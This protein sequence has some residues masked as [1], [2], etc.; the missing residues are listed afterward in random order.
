[1]NL[2][3]FALL[4]GVILLIGFS[5]NKSKLLGTPGGNMNGL[6]TAV[7]AGGCYWCMDASF[8]KISGLKDVISGHAEGQ[9][10]HSGP[11]GK[12]EAI[13]VIY[14][15]MSISYSE[16][17]D[18]YIRQFDPTDDGGSFH[19]RGA[20]YKSYVYYNNNSEKDL[21]LKLFDHLNKIGIF[22]KPIVTKVAKL[23]NF[24]PVE[25]SEQHFY[26][27]N[28]DRYHSYREAS[29]RDKYIQ[30]IWG[31]IYDFSFKKPSKDELKK[32]LSPIQFDVTQ[33]N[34]T[35]TSFNNE[36]WDNHKDGIYVD[37][38]SHEPLFSSKDKFDSGT[39]WPSFTK[40]IDPRFIVRN[41]DRA[42]GSARV[43]VK[44]KYA[45]SHLGHVFDDGPAPAHLRYCLDSAALKFIPKEELQKDGYGNFAWLFK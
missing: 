10:D 24:T 13:K 41:E 39:G 15:P 26:K 12:V 29:G 19:D 37:I 14:D 3:L 27:K 36:Y 33:N 5:I 1:M 43:E 40:P 17:L 9:T 6:S 31:N 8:E 32:K 7:F 42:L 16:L 18:Y 34:G 23:T 45:Q 22:G 11:T 4:I 25:E 30:K 21:A 28:P 35:E 44:S 2:K 38:V 20:E